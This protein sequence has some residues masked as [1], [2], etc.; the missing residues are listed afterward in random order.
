MNDTFK[1]YVLK[2]CDTFEFI[3]LLIYLFALLFSLHT[4]EEQRF[5]TFGKRLLRTIFEHTR[6]E[7][8]RKEHE[9]WNNFIKRSFTIF[10]P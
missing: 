5:R 3:Y 1:N 7:G 4:K 8:G 10:I 2:F 6:G 9:A